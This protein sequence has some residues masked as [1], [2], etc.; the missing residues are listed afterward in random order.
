MSINADI[1]NALLTAIYESFSNIYCK[2]K[3]TIPGAK[4]IKLFTAT[5]YDDLPRLMFVSK[6]NSLPRVVP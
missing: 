6:A 5:I 3:L 4:V 2:E 1:E